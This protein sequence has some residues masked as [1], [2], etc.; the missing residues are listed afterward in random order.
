M[1]MQMVKNRAVE[2]KRLQRGGPVPQYLQKRFQ[3]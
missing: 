1:L 3:K 2:D